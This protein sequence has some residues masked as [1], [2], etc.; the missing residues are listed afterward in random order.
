MVDADRLDAILGAQGGHGSKG[1]YGFTGDR[2]RP[3]HRPLR[4]KGAFRI[5]SG[6]G[7]RRRCGA[8]AG[9][10][11]GQ[12][13]R[14]PRRPG[15][16]AAFT[17]LAGAVVTMG[18]AAHPGTATAELV[19]G[20][21]CGLRDD[22]EGQHAHAVPAAEEAALAQIPAVST[23]NT[24][25]WPLPDPAHD[26]RVGTGMDRVH[27]R[28]PDRAVA[29]HRHPREEDHRGGLPVTSD[30]QTAT[31]TTL[32]PRV[33]GHRHIETGSTGSGTS[34]TKRTNRWSEPGNAPRVMATPRSPAIGLLRL[35]E[36]TTSPR[37]QPAPRPRPTTHH[38]PASNRIN[39]FAGSS[40]HSPATPGS[41]PQPQPDHGSPR[42]WTPTNAL[43][44]NTK[45][46][47]TTHAVIIV[48]RLRTG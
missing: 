41:H 22:G 21:G 42:E 12:V 5:W 16:A 28:R 6:P 3:A 7:A 24:G 20:R 8:R 43:S 45:L 32:A 35:D 30:A 2:G 9:R 1:A 48:I 25:P 29:A 36:T 19:V 26:R 4:R 46:A 39:D 23:V 27:R 47:A 17:D 14:D 37:R 15:P 33:R 10:G 13:E 38:H 44:A 11:R 18:R 34:P 31:P 40:W